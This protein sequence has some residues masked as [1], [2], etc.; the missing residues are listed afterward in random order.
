MDADISKVI[1]VYIFLGFLYYHFS[2]KSTKG[3]K[4][5]QKVGNKNDVF[6]YLIIIIA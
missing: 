5:D 1:I 3:K 2:K 4:Q 6:I